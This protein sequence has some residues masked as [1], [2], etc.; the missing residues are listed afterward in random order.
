M[1]GLKEAGHRAFCQTQLQNAT[2][3]QIQVRAP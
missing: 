2:L 1:A 3:P